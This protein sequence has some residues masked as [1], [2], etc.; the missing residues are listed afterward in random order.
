MG[1]PRQRPRS[2]PSPRSSSRSARRKTSTDIRNPRAGNPQARPGREPSLHAARQPGRFRRRQDRRQHLRG[3]IRTRSR[4]RPG[5]GRTSRL[6]LLRVPVGRRGGKRPE[7]QPLRGVRQP[8]PDLWPGTAG[9]AAGREDDSALRDRCRQRHAQRQHRPGRGRNDELPVPL[10]ADEQLRHDDPLR[11]GPEILG[12]TDIA[13][14]AH[15]TGLTQGSIYH[16]RLVV[17]N[18]NG[19]LK[20]RDATFAP[21]APAT[22]GGVYIDAVHSDSGVV[23][24]SIN[25]GGAPTTFHV[26]Y[27]TEDCLVNPG[28]CASTAETSSI[29]A[30][31]RSVPVSAELTGLDPGHRVPLRG[32]RHQPERT[33]KSDDFRFTTFPPDRNPHRRMRQRPCAPADGRRSPARLPRLRAGLGRGHRWL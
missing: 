8:G 3:R 15:L 16:Y 7:R 9:D 6:H 12:S 1:S 21:S 29:G 14:S 28:A 2:S 11:P 4:V 22:I 13:V 25:P 26:D 18:A 17:E 23:H 24:A 33:V 27:G 30:G 20:T 31:L 10:R 32:R 19:A 5:R